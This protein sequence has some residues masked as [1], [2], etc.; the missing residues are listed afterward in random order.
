[1][2]RIVERELS[3]AIVSGMYVVHG[4]LGFGYLEAIYARSLEQVLVAAGLHVQ[5]E[6][7]LPVMFRGEQVGF[8]RVDML[9]N[10]RVIVEIKATER[11]SDAAFRQLRSYVTGMRLDLGILLHFGPSAKF[12]RVL[13]GY[14]SRDRSSGDSGNSGNSVLR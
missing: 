10:D 6:V 8:H 5:R 3:Y 14:R 4:E 2:A 7:P 11:L 13:G 9:I 12:H 1:M